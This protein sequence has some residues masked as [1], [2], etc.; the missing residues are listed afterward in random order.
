MKYSEI[1]KITGVPARRI[2]YYATEG[3]LTLD[4]KNPGRGVGRNFTWRNLLELLIIKE[5]TKIGLEFSTIKRALFY[6]R[7]YDRY[8][9]DI[10]DPE[11][12]TEGLD[13]F[14]N[15]SS[16][17]SSTGVVIVRGE[18]PEN[19]IPSFFYAEAAGVTLVYLNRLVA[20]LNK[21]LE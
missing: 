12:Y 1:E 2:R 13:F 3:L 17:P 20:K 5:Y 14:L 19:D 9:H 6:I 7:Q 18:T 4:E 10:F 8:G 15:L 21:A 16:E 11:S